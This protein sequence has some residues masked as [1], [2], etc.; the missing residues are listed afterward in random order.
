MKKKISVKGGVI[1]I[2]TLLSITSSSKAE[3]N[4]YQIRRL[5]LYKTDCKLDS[6]SREIT[7][8]NS[9]EFL[10]VCQNLSFYPEG[11]KIDCADME[12]E[13]SCEVKT[14]SKTFNLK[15]LQ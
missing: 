4:D 11:V 2:I 12:D 1:L 7:A 14:K 3:I 13:T 15:Q 8:E 9:I 10:A 6:L 5:V